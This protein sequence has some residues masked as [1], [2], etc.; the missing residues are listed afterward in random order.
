MEKQMVL[1]I[2][3]DGLLHTGR[4]AIEAPETFEGN[5][6]NG[7]FEALHVYVQEADVVLVSWRF[8]SKNAGVSFREWLDLHEL[9][10][11]EARIRNGAVV[12]TKLISA[13]VR[14]APVVKHDV[15]LS[16]H[17]QPI[18]LEL[19]WPSFAALRAFSSIR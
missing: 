13:Y 7:A 19:S 3:V 11:R 6:R 9:G 1:A 12:P 15:I 8:L 14:L 16:S 4:A 17:A 2:E 18:G 5:P 10:W